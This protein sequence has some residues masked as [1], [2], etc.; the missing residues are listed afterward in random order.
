MCDTWVAEGPGPSHCEQ[1]LT[2]WRLIVPHLSLSLSDASI[3]SS[4]TSLA[5][6]V[7]PPSRWIPAVTTLFRHTT[8]AWCRSEEEGPA[9]DHPLLQGRQEASITTDPA[10][11]TTR[12]QVRANSLNSGRLKLSDLASS[13]LEG[14]APGSGVFL[15]SGGWRAQI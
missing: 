4:H 3:Q 5:L 8:T 13:T 14:G 12:M 10:R 7:V 2:R 1:L 11:S 9:G 15:H 6:E